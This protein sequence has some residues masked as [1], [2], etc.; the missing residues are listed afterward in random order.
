MAQLLERLLEATWAQ[1]FRIPR[2]AYAVT[3]IAAVGLALAAAGEMRLG[4]C[5]VGSRA[6]G[7]SVATLATTH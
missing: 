6:W 1:H 4:A 2:W 5:G 3:A 7:R